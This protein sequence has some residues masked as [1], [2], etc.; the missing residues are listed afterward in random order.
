MGLTLRRD[1]SH[2]TTIVFAGLVLMLQDKPAGFLL[3]NTADCRRRI[4]CIYHIS[5]PAFIPQ[6]ETDIRTE[7]IEVCRH[8]GIRSLELIIVSKSLDAIFDII[9]D[10]LLLLLILMRP[11]HALHRIIGNSAGRFRLLGTCQRHCTHVPLFSLEQNLRSCHQP[12]SRLRGI[13]QRDE[14]TGIHPARLHEE[15]F[16]IL[17]S[18]SH[19]CLSCQH[20]LSESTFLQFLM[21]AFKI[22]GIGITIRSVF[23]QSRI[24]C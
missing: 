18:S 3:R 13:N 14:E 11:F 22:F 7:M 6:T 23:S 20:N 24:R 8:R 2:K 17:I 12:H 9:R 15:T 21:K 19:S 4:E 16:E 5:Q 10:I 1:R